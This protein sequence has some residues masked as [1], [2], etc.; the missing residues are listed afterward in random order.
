[1]THRLPRVGC[2]RGVISAPRARMPPFALV[3]GPHHEGQ[4]LDADD[5]D[6]RPEHERQQPE[7]VGLA[8]RQLVGAA[9]ERLAHGEQRVRADVAVHDAE[10]ADGE[11]GV[12]ARTTGP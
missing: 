11:S 6:E 9:F 12:A 8:H 7:D 2:S 10:G 5:D 1:M 3:V 4:V